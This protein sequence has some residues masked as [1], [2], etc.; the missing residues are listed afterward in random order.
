MND[1]KKVIG[2]GIAGYGVYRA[3]QS[4]G[5]S[6]DRLERKGSDLFDALLFIA[7]GAALFVSIDR[8]ANAAHQLYA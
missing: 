2:F 4:F 7:A 8:A 1:F 5:E 3:L 6:A